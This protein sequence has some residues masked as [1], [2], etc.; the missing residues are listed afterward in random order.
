[1]KKQCECGCGKTTSLVPKRSHDP[2]RGIIAGEPRRFA[3]RACYYSWLSTQRSP[4]CKRGHVKTKPHPRGLRCRKC[5]RA[6]RWV[7]KYG[8]DLE[9]ALEVPEHCEICGRH[10]DDVPHSTLTLDHC[11]TT[12]AHRGW[13][14]LQCNALLGYAADDI[15]VLRKAIKYLKERDPMYLM[16]QVERATR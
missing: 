1:M 13:L 6:N 4:K 5:D 7:R 8:I 11:H 15:Q 10:E 14:C 16:P 2:A 3:S 9:T 12:E